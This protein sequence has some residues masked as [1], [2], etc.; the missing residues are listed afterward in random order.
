MNDVPSA[1]QSASLGSDADSKAPDGSQSNLNIATQKTSA[2]ARFNERLSE[3]C[4]SILVKE[5]RQALKSRQFIWTYLAIL[6]CVGVWTVLG[7]S[8]SSSQYEAGRELLIGF[9]VIL[10]FPLGLIIP[11]G[12]YRSLAREFEDGTI[13]LISITT[14]KPHQ[15]V[16]GK[17]GS[18]FLQMLIYL[19]ILAPCVCF[20]YLLRGIGIHQ[21]VLGISIA[22]G[23]SICLTVLGLFLAGVFRS[24]TLGVGV[25]V[26]FVLFLGWLYYGWCQVTYE[27]TRYGDAQYSENPE[28]VILT[29]G[30]VAFFGSTAALLLVTSAAQISFPAD[31][32]STKIR[33]AMF[34][35]QILF[36][37]FAIMLVPIG[38]RSDF[39]VCGLLLWAGH[40]W[41]IMGF[42]MIGESAFLSRRVQR[43]LPRS[44][45][46]RSLFS[47]FMPGSGRGFLFAVANI[48]T[49]AIVLLLVVLFRDWL[50]DD[51]SR[52]NYVARWGGTAN[53]S[54]SEELILQTVISCL[55]V[56]WFLSIIYLTM[57][58]YDSR[59]SD[60]STGVGPT[61]SLLLGALF[62]A[63]LS[64]GSFVLHMNTVGWQS[65]NTMTMP[66]VLNWYWVTTEL[67]DSGLSGTFFNQAIWYLLFALLKI[68]VIGIAFAVA[69]R[70]LLVRPI[71]VPERVQIENQKPI[72]SNV[73]VGESIDEIFGELKNKS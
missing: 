32:R 71:A 44:F 28:F 56:T 6:V 22:V 41:L 40:Y 67:A 5:T 42:L 31:N 58:Y 65:N 27:I 12:A 20:T 38:P 50:L 37:A 36:F 19:S 57:R 66:L 63:F 16:V 49:C 3:W 51:F 35:Q 26:L 72:S 73:A 21:I 13:N 68:L 10:G 62:V 14:M 64:I 17:F 53:W 8:T 45:A 25:S 33:I 1:I 54:V 48:W 46:S 70:E 69:S 30:M 7:L 34:V 60:W 61:V 18:A 59:K 23:G 29:Y 47:L 24:R 55:F 39:V 11:F 15:I 43:T 52:Q 4:S 2:L 9:W